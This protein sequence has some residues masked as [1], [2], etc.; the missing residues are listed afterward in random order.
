MPIP[1]P[2]IR[3]IGSRAT[4]AVDLDL[5]LINSR[6]PDDSYGLECKID[7]SALITIAALQAFI[8]QGVPMESDR[9]RRSYQWLRKISSSCTTVEPSLLRANAAI[10]V[11]QNDY[12][13]L[14][15]DISRLRELVREITVINS[16][17][18]HIPGLL[19]AIECL[20]ELGGID[21]PI[22]NIA[23]KKIFDLLDSTLINPAELAYAIQIALDL[24]ISDH[25]SIKKSI[26]NITGLFN[27]TQKLWRDCYAETAYVIIDLSY[28]SDKFEIPQQ[29]KEAVITATDELI[30]TYQNPNQSTKFSNIPKEIG[31]NNYDRSI[32]LNALILRAII[33]S[34]VFFSEKESFSLKFAHAYLRRIYEHYDGAIKTIQRKTIISKIGFPVA[35]IAGIIFGAT[36]TIGVVKGWS[37]LN[38]IVSFVSGFISIGTWVYSFYKGKTNQA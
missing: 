26:E 32:Y 37:L 33:R 28:I 13:E 25:E 30:K 6:N 14:E 12:E 23:E 24:N 36:I 11:G 34:A 16:G 17:A 38:Q 18:D 7:G 15:A 20:N 19:L 35:T 31:T 2:Q 8:E 9:L 1:T 27:R 4:A 5:A 29:L 22:K 3:E 21:Q 10:A